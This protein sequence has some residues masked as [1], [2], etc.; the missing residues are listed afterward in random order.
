MSFIIVHFSTLQFG[1]FYLPEGC[2]VE[3]RCVAEGRFEETLMGSCHI[4]ALCSVIRGVRDCYCNPG[5]EGDGRE[6]CQ[7]T[8][9]LFGFANDKIY[10]ESYEHFAIHF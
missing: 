8:F 4:D 7:G 1:D 2:R 6:S 3:F 9:L 5:Y 10:K